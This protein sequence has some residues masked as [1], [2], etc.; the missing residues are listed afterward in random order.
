M[1]T[2]TVHRVFPDLGRIWGM[3]KPVHGYTKQGLPVHLRTIDHLPNKTRINRANA[4]LAI[5]ITKG[6]GS[7][8]CAYA[9][10]AFDMLALP[11]A[12][13]QGLF[14]IVQWVA[15][16]FLQLVL[17]SIIMVGQNIAGE[18]SDARSAKTFEDTE[19][20]IDRLD[21][22]TTG[23]LADAVTEL[24][25]HIDTRLEAYG[26]QAVPDQAQP[27]TTPVQPSWD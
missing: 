7:M 27:P 14:G 12:I 22:H 2:S 10:A 16:F 1:S 3:D 24:K 18:A 19:K 15:S 9:F 11:T 6:V 20:I 26:L 5:K 4:W 8:W 17:L 13:S 23:G 21:V 25:S